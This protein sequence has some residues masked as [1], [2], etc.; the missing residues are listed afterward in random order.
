MD[1]AGLAIGIVGL[2]TACR[3]CYDFFTTVNAAQAES[4]AHLRELEIQQSILKAWGFHW[5][6]QNEDGSDPG[7][8]DHARR[9]RSKLHQYLLSN[10]F[11]AEGVFKT[12]SALADTLCNREKLIKRYGFQLQ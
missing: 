3:D 12:L 6:I 9:K 1:V 7:Y 10:R 11:K 8:S 2:Y 4:S 5:Q